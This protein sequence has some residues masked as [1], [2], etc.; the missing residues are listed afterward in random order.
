V[1]LPFLA[2]VARH[3]FYHGQT[4]CFFLQGL[5]FL[6]LFGLISG[7]AGTFLFSSH[8]PPGPI[9][10]SGFSGR[11]SGPWFWGLRDF[12]HDP[13]LWPSPGPVFFLPLVGVFFLYVAVV[14]SFLSCVLPGAF[15]PTAL[16]T[17]WCSRGWLRVLSVGV[18]SVSWLLIWGESSFT[19]VWC[20]SHLAAALPDFSSVFF[21]GPPFRFFFGFYGLGFFPLCFCYMF[22]SPPSSRLSLRFFPTPLSTKRLCF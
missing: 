20:T 16:G 13:P 10:A 22:P 18:C 3:L 12:G 6:A 1:G 4:R 17:G 5:C 21:S 2:N 11:L 19:L 7:F 15:L 8:P 9:C 14:F